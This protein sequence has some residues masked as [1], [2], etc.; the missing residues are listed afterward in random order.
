MNDVASLL[1]LTRKI[2]VL[3]LRLEERKGKENVQRPQGQH[4]LLVNELWRAQGAL[5]ILLRS[6]D[7]GQGLVHLP[8]ADFDVAPQ[9]FEKPVVRGLALVARTF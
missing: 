2:L 6:E 1:K 9:R 3:S 7:G 5:K 4:C 8:G